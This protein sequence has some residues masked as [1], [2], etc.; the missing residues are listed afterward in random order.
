LNTINSKIDQINM[1]L[2][3][4]IDEQNIRLGLKMSVNNWKT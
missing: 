2:D 3:A 4:M 1:K